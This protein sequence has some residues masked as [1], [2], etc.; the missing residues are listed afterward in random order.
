MCMHHEFPLLFSPY[1][2]CFI[3]RFD[4]DVSAKPRRLL[5]GFFAWWWQILTTPEEEVLRV[6]GLDMA[7]FIRT[8][9]FAAEESVHRLSFSHFLHCPVD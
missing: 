5:P 3:D 7:V 1:E 2:P 8:L 6:A 4:K 9:V